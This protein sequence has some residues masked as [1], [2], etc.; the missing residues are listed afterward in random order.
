M[1]RSDGA[2]DHGSGTGLEAGTAVP[3]WA[4]VVG[5]GAGAMMVA[6]AGLNSYLVTV[7]P[8]VYRALG[9]W[10]VE[11]SPWALDPQMRLWSTTFGEHPRAWGVLVG[12]GFEAGVGALALS[13]DARRRTVGLGGVAAFH[14]GLLT[15]GLW[16]WA[17]PVLA[18]VVPATVSSAAV[19]WPAP[20]GTGAGRR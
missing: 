11:L 15:M 20:A 16:V 10:F 2:V 18:V 1:A 19:A 3:R 17:V 13:R 8:E 7:R 12:V 14:V 9:D 6:G 4:R 5:V